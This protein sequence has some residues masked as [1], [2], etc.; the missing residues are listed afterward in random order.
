MVIPTNPWTQISPVPR[1]QALYYTRT[2]P[3]LMPNC[4]KYLLRTS[5]QAFWKQTHVDAAWCPSSCHGVFF[6]F[7]F[8][9][10]LGLSEAQAE[11]VGSALKYYSRTRT[12]GFDKV[13]ER[14]QLRSLGVTGRAKDPRISLYPRIVFCVIRRDE[15][16][17]NMHISRSPYTTVGADR[18]YEREPINRALTRWPQ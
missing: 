17:S 10:M 9:G 4:R 16:F 11:S 5:E 7:H 3:S 12:L 14:A 8:L 18:V 6:V 15:G 2:H 1:C 13:T